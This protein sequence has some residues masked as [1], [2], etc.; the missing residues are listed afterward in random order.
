D[1][2]QVMQEEMDR[3]ITNVIGVCAM[4]HRMTLQGFLLPRDLIYKAM[5]EYNPHGL[6][7]RQPG[8]RKVVR[9]PIISVG[10]NEQWSIDGHDK[11][12]AYGIGIY[13]I[14]DVY[15]GR[16]LSLQAM[17]SNRCSDDVHCVFLNAAIKFGGFPLQIASDRGSEI[18]EIIATQIAF[19][20]SYSTVGLDQ[21]FPY[22]LLKSTQNITIERSWCNVPENVVDQVKAALNSSFESGLV[23]DGDLVHQSLLNWLAPPVV[24][25]ALDDFMKTFDSYPV[26]YQKEK[27]NPSGASRNEIYFNPQRWGGRECLQPFPAMEITK[28]FRKNA[29]RRAQMT[30]VSP[31]V[32]QCCMDIVHVEALEY[33]PQSWDM[34]WT[35]FREVEPKVQKEL[36]QLWLMT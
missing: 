21:V 6:A 2:V 33:P 12:S 28:E 32:L 11:L 7:T 17:P 10:P 20:N 9:S 25:Q 27:V 8:S 19:R 26:R 36:Q 22:K 13:G 31:E 5:K 4:K 15:S 3:D 23:H 35:L 14:R 29:E 18:G 16:L 34:A 24:Q 30:W 1:A